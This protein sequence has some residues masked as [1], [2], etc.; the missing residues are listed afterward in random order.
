MS[1]AVLKQAVYT[2][3]AKETKLPV[4]WE[5]QATARPNRPYA[6][7]NIITGAVMIGED[8]QRSHLTGT[9]PNQQTQFTWEGLRK[10]TVSCNIWADNAIDLMADVQGSI[11]KQ[12]NQNA[13]ILAGIAPTDYTNV[14]KLSQLFDTRYEDRAQMDV[15]FQTVHVT[16]DDAVPVEKVNLE[17][18]SVTAL[19][20]TDEIQIGE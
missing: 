17:D 18:Q 4:I 13:F 9:A 6:S 14:Q 12:S 7:L 16:V 15:I 5:E 19:A 11:R 3:F 10:L 8:D 2:W 20:S 1:F